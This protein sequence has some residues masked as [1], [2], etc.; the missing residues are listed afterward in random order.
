VPALDYEEMSTSTR[1]EP[2]IVI[3]G[4]VAEAR[5]IQEARFATR[6]APR[7]NARM[8]P[9]E[10]VQ[11]ASLDEAGRNLLR[12]A[13]N[14]FG[15]SARAHDRILKVARTIADLAV[16]EAIGAEHVAEAIQYR[17]LDRGEGI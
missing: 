17:C 12:R 16:A 9:A 10:T 15:L 8:T 11:W 2:S 13:M 5:A 7:L 3:R 4:R 14:H 1:G 6:P